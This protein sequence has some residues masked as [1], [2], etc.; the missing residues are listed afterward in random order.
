MLASLVA[1]KQRGQEIRN[2]RQPTLALNAF[3]TANLVN[4]VES[5]NCINRMLLLKLSIISES[6]L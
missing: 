5:Q 1:C 6:C 4:S 2:L 3:T